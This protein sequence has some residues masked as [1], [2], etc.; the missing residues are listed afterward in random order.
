MDKLKDVLHLKRD[1]KW[2]SLRHWLVCFVVC[3]FNVDVGPEIELI[4]PSDTTFSTADLSAICFNSFPERQDTEISEDAYFHFVIRNNSPD[5]SLQSPKAPYGSSSLFFGNSVFH[6][7]F[8]SVTKRSFS[9]KALVIISNHDFPSFFKTL[10]Q[11][12]IS[13]G[14]I[15][16]PTRL[17]AAC[18]EISSWSA[19]T[20]GRQELPFLGTLLTLEMYA[21]LHG[22]T[23]SSL[24]NSC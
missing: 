19:P 15:S 24:L 6:Q 21:F 9:Q 7:E 8:D 23:R 1:S 4:Y 2:T 3:N 14:F 13:S 16:D 11:I 5:I 18:S 12:V 17:E 20:V 10:L 22:I